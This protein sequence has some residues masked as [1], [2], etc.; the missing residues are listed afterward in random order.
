MNFVDSH[1]HMDSFTEKSGIDLDSWWNTVSP[2]P[3]AILHVACEKSG[4]DD[5]EKISRLYPNV[6]TAFG[7]HP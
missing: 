5:A 1:C 7:I 3:D 6:Y 4:F 2:K